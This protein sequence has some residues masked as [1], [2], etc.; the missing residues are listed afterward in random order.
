MI[1]NYD[2][3]IVLNKSLVCIDLDETIIKKTKDSKLYQ[4]S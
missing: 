1:S 3:I 4:S 2:E